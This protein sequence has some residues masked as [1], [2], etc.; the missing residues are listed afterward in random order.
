MR[1]TNIIIL[2]IILGQQIASMAHKVPI[3]S[4]QI[5][6]VVKEGMVMWQATEGDWSQD[7]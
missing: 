2:A 7:L 5:A 1:D 6:M 3:L 4:F